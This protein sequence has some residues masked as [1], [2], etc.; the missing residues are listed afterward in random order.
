MDG[1]LCLPSSSRKCDFDI[2]WTY[3]SQRFHNPPKY[4]HRQGNEVSDYRMAVFIVSK[5]F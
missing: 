3:E 5:P 1:L 2:T 4:R